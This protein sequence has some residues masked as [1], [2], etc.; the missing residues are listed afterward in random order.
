METS[1]E[2]GLKTADIICKKYNVYNPRKPILKTRQ[3][4][5]LITLPFVILDKLLYK[6]KLK[7]I[8]D[9][10]NSIVLLIIYFTILINIIFKISKFFINNK[11][12]DKYFKIFF[13]AFFANI[14]NN[15]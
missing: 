3:Y 2:I 4:A 1:C 8:T 10:I 12:L 11:G 7:P 9:S 5:L 6:L 14:I 15:K 13:I